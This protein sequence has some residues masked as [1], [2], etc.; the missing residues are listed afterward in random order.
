MAS[1]FDGL[2]HAAWG[3]VGYPESV[4]LAAWGWDTCSGYGSI[5]WVEVD[6]FVANGREVRCEAHQTV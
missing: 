2:A 4:R 3:S 6:R 5:G 1:R